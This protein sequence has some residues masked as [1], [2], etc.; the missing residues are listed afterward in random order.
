MGIWVCKV[1]GLSLVSRSELLKHC[2]LKHGHYVNRFRHS[3]PYSNCPCTLRFWNSLLRHVYHS[4][5][6]QNSLKTSTLSKFCCQ[7]CTIQELTNEHE[8]FSHVN[9][10]LRKHETVT[11]MFKGCEFKTNIY[12]TFH[13]HKYRKHVY[14]TSTSLSC[15]PVLSLWIKVSP[16]CVMLKVI[17]VMRQNMHILQIRLIIAV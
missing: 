11:C 12:N 3:C 17:V 16:R 7:L 8:Y 1:C 13:T 15:P 5:K 14:P 9:E 6:T 10:H 2:K 4:H